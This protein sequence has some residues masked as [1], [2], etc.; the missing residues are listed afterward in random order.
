M[1]AFVEVEKRASV[2]FEVRYERWMSRN[3]GV[4]AG[5]SGT[6]A[7]ETLFGGGFGCTGVIPFGKKPRAL[8]AVL[9]Q[10]E[11]RLL[12]GAAASVPWLLMLLQ[13]TYGCGLRLGEVLRLQ[14]TDLDSARMVLHVRCAKGRKDRLVPLSQTLLALLRDYWRRY[15]PRLW[16]FPGRHAGKPL[17]VG[18]VQRPA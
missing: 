7:P 15:R 6:V 1:R 8:P 2:G 11:V 14:V 16:L 4:W 18:S 17:N 5:L 10:D 12:F 3:F 13:R 9:S